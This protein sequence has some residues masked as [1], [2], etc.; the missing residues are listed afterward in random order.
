MMT[1]RQVIFMALLTSVALQ[2]LFKFPQQ[3]TRYTPTPRPSTD[4]PFSMVTACFPTLTSVSDFV[5]PTEAI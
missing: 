1:E 2:K 3:R 4:V 5:Y